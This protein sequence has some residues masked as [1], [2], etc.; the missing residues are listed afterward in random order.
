[1]AYVYFKDLNYCHN[2]SNC[3]FGNF[4]WFKMSKLFVNSRL[5]KIRISVNNFDDVI[6]LIATLL[7]GLPSCSFIFCCYRCTAMVDDKLLSKMK[8]KFC[9]HYILNFFS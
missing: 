3:Y 5:C 4:A 2:L 9:L 7:S 6:E 8:V 1:M